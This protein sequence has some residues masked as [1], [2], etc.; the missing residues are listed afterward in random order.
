MLNHVYKSIILSTAFSLSVFFAKAQREYIVT[1]NPSNAAIVKIDSLAGVKYLQWSAAYNQSTKEYTVIGTLNPGTSP[2]YLFTLDAVSGNTITH[3]VLNNSNNVICLQYSTST[4]ILYAIVRE[5]GVYY[6]ATLNKIS[7]TYT[8]IHNIPGIDGVNG[9]TIDEAN[10]RLYLRAVDANPNFAIWT[11]DLATGN[12]IYH[13]ST[14]G[15]NSLRYS[16]IAHKIYALT[17]RPGPSPG[18]SVSGICTVDPVTG[19]VTDI[20]DLPGVTGNISGDHETLNENDHLYIFAG[21]EAASPGVAFLYSVDFNTG[22][23]VHRIPIPS[24]GVTDHDN[25]IF[26]RYDNNAGVLY[27]LLWEAHTVIA[28]PPPPSPVAVDSS[29]SLTIKTKIY[30]N[31][32]GNTLTVDKNPTK[33]KVSLYLYNTLGQLVMKDKIINDG[34]NEISLK[35]LSPGYYYYKFLSD[36]NILLEGSILKQ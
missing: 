34:H 31:P 13:V 9:F 22:N 35:N 10:Q 5:N 2:S 4:G 14:Q 15:I 29:C 24:S 25:L 26:F 33:C 18:S 8:L 21:V 16:N 1:V 7:G 12:I 6:L 17:H 11:I 20:A 32:F 36:D 23:I 3:P 28:P 19:I 30:P 27:A